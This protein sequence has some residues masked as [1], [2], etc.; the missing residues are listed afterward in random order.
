MLIWGPATGMSLTQRI[1]WQHVNT[2]TDLAAWSPWWPKNLDYFL[3][4]INFNK[5]LSWP[6]TGQPRESNKK[7]QSQAIKTASLDHITKPSVP[8]SSPPECLL[9]RYET[10]WSEEEET[11]RPLLYDEG[12]EKELD[13]YQQL[14]VSP[15]CL[16]LVEPDT[17]QC[18]PTKC[19]HSL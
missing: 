19:K 7:T 11:Q 8:S 6:P 17:L 10:S 2:D 3:L 16:M 13:E 15:S 18:S 1:V 5:T 12:G 14:T 4:D 9:C